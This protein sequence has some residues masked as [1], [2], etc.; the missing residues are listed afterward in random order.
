MLLKLVAAISIACI[1]GVEATHTKK[2]HIA[3]EL[4]QT[5]EKTSSHQDISM[6][7]SSKRFRIIP[8]PNDIDASDIAFD[9][10]GGLWMIAADD[11]IWYFSNGD[12]KRIDGAAR[13]ITVDQSGVVWVVNGN[14]NAWGG[15]I[16]KRQGAGGSWAMIDGEAV[17]VG[18][19]STVPGVV[20]KGGM[21]W[22]RQSS[23]WQNLSPKD[24]K[25]VTNYGS[26]YVATLNDGTVQHFV[27]GGTSYATKADGSYG[28]F[29]GSWQTL[30]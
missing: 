29:P 19:K 21:I 2:S 16:Y 27:Y 11:G 3:H 12:W 10:D 1:L 7:N 14:N 30:P 24:N 22:L 25:E 18:G 13:R 20:N 9:K 28:S 23:S 15:N 8:T 17:T 5:K 26:S 4:M 6:I